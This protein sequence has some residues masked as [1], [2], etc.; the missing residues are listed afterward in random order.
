MGRG[1]LSPT[2]RSGQEGSGVSGG[3]WLPQPGFEQYE[4]ASVSYSDNAWSPGK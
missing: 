3:S 2:E 4:M 1:K